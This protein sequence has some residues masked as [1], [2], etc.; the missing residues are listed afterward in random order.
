MTYALH[1]GVYPEDI[2]ADQATVDGHYDA[3]EEHPFLVDANEHGTFAG[4]VSGSWACWGPADQDSDGD[5]SLHV[6]VVLGTGDKVTPDLA[7]EVRGA[8]WDLL[9]RGS[10]LLDYALVT[11]AEDWSDDVSIITYKGN[12]PHVHRVQKED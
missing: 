6:L 9:G 11:S 12:G 5:E 2:L 10:R 3:E 7:E 1:F 4:F 8:V